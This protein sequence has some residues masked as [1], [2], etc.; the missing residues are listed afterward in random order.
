MFRKEQ[1]EADLIEMGFEKISRREFFDE[2][3]NY[4]NEDDPAKAKKFFNS[5]FIMN[6]DDMTIREIL[7]LIEKSDVVGVD[8]F[9]MKGVDGEYRVKGVLPDG[10]PV[11]NEYGW[12]NILNNITAQ[13]FVPHLDMDVPGGLGVL[14]ISAII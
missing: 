12:E 5:E 11:E 8:V 1:I 9:F 14:S 10:E 7:D 6:D 3:I 13:A 2:I 4:V